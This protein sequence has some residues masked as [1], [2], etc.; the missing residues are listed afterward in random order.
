MP[1]ALVTEAGFLEEAKCGSDIRDGSVQER[2]RYWLVILQAHP[3]CWQGQSTVE[4]G[5]KCGTI[6]TIK[7]G[8]HDGTELVAQW[9]SVQGSAL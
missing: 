8:S 5:W 3:G 9:G 1:G 2:H 4:H 6:E 7:R